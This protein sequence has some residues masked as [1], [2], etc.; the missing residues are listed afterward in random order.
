MN[1][2]KAI[3]EILN[4]SGRRSFWLKFKWV[5]F[6]LLIKNLVEYRFIGLHGVLLYVGPR[7]MRATVTMISEKS[8]MCKVL[9]GLP[10]AKREEDVLILKKGN[11]SKSVPPKDYA[12]APLNSETA[13]FEVKIE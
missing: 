5:I 13:L 10:P 1:E 12:P 8:A 9:I 3:E 2:G 4:G 11:D 7:E 6:K